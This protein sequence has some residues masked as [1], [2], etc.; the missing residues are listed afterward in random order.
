M[1]SRKPTTIAELFQ[2]YQEDFKLLYN[3]L[4]C[5]NMPPLEMFFEV[6]AAL[7]HLSRHW[8]QEEDEIAVV[9]RA[10]AHLKRGCFDA[11]KL[12][13]SDAIALFDELRKI[14][15]S[16]IDN[17]EFDKD[18][19][20]LIAKI[21]TGAE[22]AR[23]AEGDAKDRDRWHVAYELWEPV[24]AGCVRF[25]EEFYLSS[26]VSWAKRKQTVR[27]WRMRVEGFIVGALA[28][29]AASIVL[30]VIAKN[31]KAG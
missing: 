9:E 22:A 21:R 26:K 8:C 10:T 31:F 28:S 19:H 6:N 15:T 12:I 7:D 30:W 14:D 5:L 1:A 3:H 24:Y 2:F 23:L 18:M 20:H 11:F 16:I 25:R 29:A 17:G 4:Q 13:A 27:S